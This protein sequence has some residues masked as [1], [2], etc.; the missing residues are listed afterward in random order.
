MRENSLF[1]RRRLGQCLAGSLMRAI[2]PNGELWA[3][4]SG[5]SDET[6]EAGWKKLLK[7]EAADVA[8]RNI[9]GLMRAAHSYHESHSS[10]P[11]AVIANPKLPAGKRLSGL[12]LL[13]PHLDV[14]SWIQRGESCFDEKTI[15]L[16]KS[17]YESIDQ[18]KAWDDPVNLKAAR[19]LV[20]AFVA[21]Q[22]GAVRN[23]DGIPV[24]HFAFVSGNSAGTNGAFPGDRGLR[25]AAITDGTVSTLGFGQID[26]DLGPWI[27]E[28][29]G[30]ARQLFAA[31]KD[32][33]ASFGS[34]YGKGAMFATV[35]SMAGYFPI[36]EESMP[37]LEQMA[38]RSGEE[39]VD[40]KGLRQEN[41]FKASD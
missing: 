18:S 28:G 16:G 23:A 25:F 7:F 33:P 14:E 22:S 30:T 11:P 17:L 19:T 34:G 1:S 10:L 36:N 8:R 2:L 4:L 24:S 15:Q 39:L 9:H 31:T 32:M 29:L 5:K 40:F 20:P 26:H 35:D 13:L 38:T 12:V 27:A 6:I 3:E 37:I 41:P 21:P